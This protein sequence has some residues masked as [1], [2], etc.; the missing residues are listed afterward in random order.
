MEVQD[1]ATN[2]EHGRR[3]MDTP[4]TA[5]YQHQPLDTTVGQI[6]LF[7]LTKHDAKNGDIDGTIETFLLDD[8]PPFQAL[9][10]VWVR[11]TLRGT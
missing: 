1:S 6:R 11:I 5:M 7:R 2:Q 9:S 8:I 3:E 10:Y 4:S